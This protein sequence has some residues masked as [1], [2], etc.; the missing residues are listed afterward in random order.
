MA[1][2]VDDLLGSRHVRL[3]EFEERRAVENREKW[4][5]LLEEDAN[6]LIRLEPSRRLPNDGI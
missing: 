3:V 1:A 6:Q 2:V 5:P 4:C